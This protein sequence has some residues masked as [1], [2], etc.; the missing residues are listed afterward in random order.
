VFVV[1]ALAVQKRLKS[2]L[3]TRIVPFSDSLLA[4][5]FSVVPLFVIASGPSRPAPLLLAPDP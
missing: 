2:L 5:K 1:T 3:R 4:H